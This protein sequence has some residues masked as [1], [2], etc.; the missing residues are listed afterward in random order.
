MGVLGQTPWEQSLGWEFLYKWFID[1]LNPHKSEGSRTGQQKKLN[2][3]WFQEKSRL[4]LIPR[5]AP[6]HEWHPRSLD[7]RGRGPG[8][9]MPV[10]VSHSSGLPG[11]SR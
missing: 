3:M 8:C 4:S 7:S 11:V 1:S 2:E 10:S 9:P 5:G 6:Q